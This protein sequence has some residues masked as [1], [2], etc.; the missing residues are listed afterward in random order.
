MRGNVAAAAL[1]AGVFA[2]QRVTRLLVIEGS[3]IPFDQG[4]VFAVMVGVAANALLARSRLEVIG[5]VQAFLGR[6]AG[7]NLAVAI[8]AAERSFAGSDLMAASAIGGAVQGSVRAG[9]RSGR[10]LRRSW[11]PAKY[12]RRE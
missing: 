4:K 10:D 12:C 11:N 3:W 2:L 6:Q 8:E 1:Q 9:E 5:R 7:G